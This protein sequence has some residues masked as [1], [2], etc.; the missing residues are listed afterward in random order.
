LEIQTV[1]LFDS[2]VKNTTFVFG[3]Q[4]KILYV[5]KYFNLLL[6]ALFGVALLTACNN[7]DNSA[8]VVNTVNYKDTVNNVV[9]T[10]VEI[11]S[12]TFW[13]GSASYESDEMPVHKVTLSD[14]YMGQTEVTQA[15][16]NAVMGD[17]TNDSQFKGA[18]LPVERVNYL[19]V[20]AFITRLDSLT[21]KSYRLPTEA[22]WE[23]AA[24]A[25]DSIAR[26]LYPGTNN[27]DSI[28]SYA[29][30]YL[31][32]GDKTHQVA[33]RYPNSFGLYDMAGNVWEWCGDIY[34]TYPATPQV[35]PHGVT[36]GTFGIVV[37]GG[38]WTVVDKGYRV[39]NRNYMTV[40]S[41]Y[42]SLGFRLARTK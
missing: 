27:I 20:I 32:A 19:Q 11:S 12:N 16:W 39:T 38:A 29:W 14:Y 40:T 15:L 37:R 17:S 5:M 25:K 4:P 7:D 35:N 8:P 42:G 2:F 22:E 26:T 36:T 23:Y 10:M 9:F 6:P 1:I 24:A 18:K 21:G 30:Y 41:R 33:T 13:M 31:N 34:G 3:N 28:G